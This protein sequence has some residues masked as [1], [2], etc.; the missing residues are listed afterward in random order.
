MSVPSIIHQLTYLSETS[1]TD[2]SSIKGIAAGAAYLSPALGEKF[3][4]LVGRKAKTEEQ[5]PPIGNGY[6]LSE[7]V[8]VIFG[9]REDIL[10]TSLPF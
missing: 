3:R 10:L 7:A 8:S 4:R 1:K 6:G 2:L 9:W 5:L